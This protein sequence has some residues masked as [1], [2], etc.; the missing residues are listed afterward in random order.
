MIRLL[1]NQMKYELP[2]NV[3]TDA[4]SFLGSLLEADPKKRPTAAEALDSVY[5]REKVSSLKC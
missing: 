5:L 2:P 3:S 4:K 1:K